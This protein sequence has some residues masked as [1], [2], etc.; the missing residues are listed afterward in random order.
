[1]CMHGHEKQIKGERCNTTKR[2]LAV[3]RER[4]VTCVGMRVRQ[5]QHPRIRGWGFVRGDS[6]FNLGLHRPIQVAASS[7]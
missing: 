7:S 1:M 4:V 6:V 3:T 2:F 5:R